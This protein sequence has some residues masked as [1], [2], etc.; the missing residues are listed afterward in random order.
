MIPGVTRATPLHSQVGKGAERLGGGETAGPVWVK[1]RHPPL[2]ETWARRASPVN[3]WHCPNQGLECT[4]CEYQ[5]R[6]WAKSGWTAEPPE[7]AEV[8]VRP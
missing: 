8:G 2:W 5:G 1:P 4:T 7:E 3:R 6:G